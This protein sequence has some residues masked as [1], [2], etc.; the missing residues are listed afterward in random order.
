MK[1]TST[2]F[3]SLLQSFFCQHLVRQKNVTPKTVTTYRDTFT[4]FLRY[5]QQTRRKSPVTLDLPDFTAEAVLGFLDHLERERKNA[6]RTRNLR[7]A[8]LRSFAHYILAFAAT[9]YAPQIQRILSIPMKRFVRPLLGFLSPEEVQ[10][11]LNAPT[12][13]TPAGRRDRVLLQL[14]YNTGARVSEIIHLRVEDLSP[15]GLATVHLKGKGR[16]ERT[17]PLWRTTRRL[18]RQWIGQNGLKPGQLLFPNRFGQ[19]LSRS[20]VAFRLGRAVSHATSGCPSLR[21]RSITPHSFRHATA[22]HMLQAGVLPEVIA[23]WLGHESPTTTHHYV[24]ADL[25]MKQK[26]LDQ[27]QSPATKGIRF[28]PKDDLLRFLDTL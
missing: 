8:A 19:A 10:A 18:L 15:N 23:L 17:V 21:G 4:L 7:L 26:A 22:M 11:L 27:M 6:V 28:H 9:D 25:T 3:A 12:P 24:E 14:L 13:T 16:K 5:M 2:R 1:P 20:G